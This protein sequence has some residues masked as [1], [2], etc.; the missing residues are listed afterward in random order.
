MWGG[1]KV[2]RKRGADG[3]IGEEDVHVGQ[4]KVEG[5]GKNREGYVQGW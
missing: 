5:N 2:G 4:D 1:G 3:H